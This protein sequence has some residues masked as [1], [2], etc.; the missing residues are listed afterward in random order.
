M[1][2]LLPLLGAMALW[3][4]RMPARRRAT[5]VMLACAWNLPALLMVNLLAMR[6]GWWQFGA[7]GGLIMGVPADLCMGWAILWGAIPVLAFPRMRLMFVAVIMLCADLLLMP[8]CA[9]AVQLGNRWLIGEAVALLFALLPAQA[10]ARWTTDDRLLKERALLQA[11]LFGGFLLGVIPAIIVEQTGGSLTAFLIKPLWLRSLLLQLLAVFAILGL[12]AVQEFVVRGKGTPV[13]Y[14]P[15]KR[16]V[17]SG[18][19]AYVANPMQLSMCLLLAAWGLMLSSYWVIGAGVMGFIYSAGLAA[20][21]EGGDLKIRYGS[22]WVAY[23]RTV[24]NWLPRWR[25]YVPERARIYIA[26]GCEPCSQ[27]RAW[28][29]R[30]SPIALEIVAAEDHPARDLRRITYEASDRTVEEGVAAFA[31]ALEHINL[32][33]AFAGWSMRLPLVRQLI[34]VLI[35]AVGGAPREIKRRRCQRADVKSVPPAVAGGS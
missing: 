15:P 16:L 30:H 28:L 25:P 32:A 10:L 13:P 1:G 14:D 17:T 7:R 4:W 3:L 21:D 20:W 31:R 29:E 22:A 19:Y 11:I 8:V 9:P 6:Y 24:R 34:Q 18:V 27:T 12:S 2:L 5:A 23:R 33:W 35:D 26:E